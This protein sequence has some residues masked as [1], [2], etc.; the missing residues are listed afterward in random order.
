MQE[1]EAELMGIVMKVTWEYFLWCSWEVYKLNTFEAKEVRERSLCR[2]WGLQLTAAE[3]EVVGIV[4]MTMEYEGSVGRRLYSPSL[5][6]FYSALEVKSVKTKKEPSKDM[7]HQ[8]TG[9]WGYLENFGITVSG[10]E[11]ES[12]HCCR[13]TGVETKHQNTSRPAS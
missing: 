5:P 13:G 7:S 6:S 10:M 3:Q 12:R 2:E 4:I 9:E 11:V 8:R 1:V